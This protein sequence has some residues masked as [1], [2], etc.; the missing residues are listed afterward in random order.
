[1]VCLS[2]W[3]DWDTGCLIKSGKFFGKNDVNKSC[4]TLN[5]DVDRTIFCYLFL[6]TKEQSFESTTSSLN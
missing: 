6:E 4:T 2:D 3:F 1:M 5:N